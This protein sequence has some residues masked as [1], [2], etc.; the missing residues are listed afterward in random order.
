VVV[1]GEPT[2]N[3]VWY[4]WQMQLVG[5]VAVN[6]LTGEN[7][8][9][10][11]FKNVECHA[12]AGI[13]N[14][15]RFFKQLEKAG[16]SSRIDHSFPDHHV[17]T[18]DEITFKNMSVFMTEKDAVKCKSFATEHHWCVPVTA[19]LSAE[20]TAKFLTLLKTKFING[21]N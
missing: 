9:L 10:S 19:Q 2:E 3:N 14:P 8:P 21:K 17:F 20:F 13:G 15:E 11:E 7:K 1:N 16:L 12:L 5:D 18:A 6:L 4:E